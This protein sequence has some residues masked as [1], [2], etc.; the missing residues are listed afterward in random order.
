MTTRRE[1]GKKGTP[2]SPS[3][4]RRPSP[5]QSYNEILHI[6][7]TSGDD[8][9]NDTTDN[10]IFNDDD[11]DDEDDEHDHEVANIMKLTTASAPK[12]PSLPPSII[13]VRV[14]AGSDIED[15]ILTTSTNPIVEMAMRASSPRTEQRHEAYKNAILMALKKRQELEH[16]NHDD[17]E[18]ETNREDYG[19]NDDGNY[20]FASN[21]EDDIKVKEMNRSDDHHGDNAKH[22][23]D[24]DPISMLELPTLGVTPP[25]SIHP[26]KGITA[27]YRGDYDN[28]DG[29][30]VPDSF[31]VDGPNANSD[32][33]SILVDTAATIDEAR[34][35]HISTSKE[36]EEERGARMGDRIAEVDREHQLVL[37][38]ACEVGDRNGNDGGMDMV[39][40]LIEQEEYGGFMNQNVIPP[41]IKYDGEYDHVDTFDANDKAKKRT[42]LNLMICGIV[43]ITIIIC[44]AVIAAVFILKDKSLPVDDGT[45][46]SN[47]TNIENSNTTTPPA[48][49]STL[50]PTMVDRLSLMV[51]SILTKNVTDP[52]SLLLDPSTSQYQALHWL[53]Y[54]DTYFQLTVNSAITE[55]D[56]GYGIAPSSPMDILTERYALAVFYFET[57]GPGWFSSGD[58]LSGSHVCLW[59]GVAC[60]TDSEETVDGSDDWSSQFITSLDFHESEAQNGK[61]NGLDGTIPPEIGILSSHLRVLDVGAQEGPKT[62]VGG[63]PTE[64][65]LLTQLTM[66]RLHDQQLTGEIPRQLQALRNLKELDLSQNFLS[67]RLPSDVFQSLTSLAVLYLYNNNLSGSIPNEIGNLSSVV[68]VDLSLNDFSSSLPTEIGLLLNLQK[69]TLDN[70][71]L[72]GSIP[73]NLGTCIGLTELFLEWNQLTGPIPAEIANIPGLNILDLANNKLSS[74]IPSEIGLLTDLVFVYLQDNKF[75]GSI[76]WEVKGLYHLFEL[77]LQGN[78]LAGSVNALFCEQSTDFRNMKRG[79]FPT[80]YNLCVDN[81]DCSTATSSSASSGSSLPGTS[82]SSGANNNTSTKE[83][84][85]TDDCLV[86]C[87]CC[88]CWE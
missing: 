23:Q 73:T 42:T 46:D 43:G 11:D 80:L 30:I 60:V 21:A 50:A 85:E 34:G 71:N 81:H 47:I 13:S 3:R 14:P 77:N 72:S 6:D 64:L 59:Y 41:D 54:D 10:I 29:G 74:S 18:G 31:H 35:R 69:L 39:G 44:G 70:N 33:V 58:W 87:N 83:G 36:E 45:S 5:R 61:G 4:R 7:T 63:I 48:S 68:E 57:N 1:D 84:N 15:D 76:P 19:G 49:S 22:H 8:D 24:E 2:S 9:E 20:G 37:V 51:S 78:Q 88:S 67:G 38:D 56:V 62:I 16:Q 86:Q 17:H 28:D 65:G 26:G 12:S 25:T 82:A 66:L 32:K 79:Q 75:T 40:G 27:G 53:V 52:Y 55:G